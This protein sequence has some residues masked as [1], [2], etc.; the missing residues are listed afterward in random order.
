VKGD[1]PERCQWQVERGRQSNEQRSLRDSVAGDYCELRA[2]EVRF[3]N[4]DQK[5]L[6]I[7]GFF[8]LGASLAFELLE[9]LL[10]L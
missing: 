9:K 2:T 7:K 4:P 5:P 10:V 3:L 8:F 6:C 1:A